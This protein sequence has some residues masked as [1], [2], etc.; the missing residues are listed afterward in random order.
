MEKG[1]RSRIFICE[2]EV[3]P[4]LDIDLVRNMHRSLKQEI[5]VLYTFGSLQEKCMYTVIESHDRLTL[6]V[7]FSGMRI[8][9]GKITE[10]D[11][12]GEGREWVQDLREMRK[13]A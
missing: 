3:V 7:F 13:A 1:L 4:D 12:Q 8:P 5:K 10:V 9:W 2:H 6:E 11:I